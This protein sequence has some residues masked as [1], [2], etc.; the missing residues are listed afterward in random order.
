[1]GVVVKSCLGEVIETFEEGEIQL[2]LQFQ[3]FS[4]ASL[5]S[6]STESS[7]I[8]AFLR[9]PPRNSRA[10]RTVTFPDGVVVSELVELVQPTRT[11]VPRQTA[12]ALRAIGVEP[13]AEP[14]DGANNAV[15]VSRM[16]ARVA[17]NGSD[18]A[19]PRLIC[20]AVVNQARVTLDRLERAL[21]DR[22]LELECAPWRFGRLQQYTVVSLHGPP[23]AFG[24]AVDAFRSEFLHALGLLALVGVFVV[25][26]AGRAFEGTSWDSWDAHLGVLLAGWTVGVVYACDAAS[27]QIRRR[28]HPTGGLINHLTRDL[29]G[30]WLFMRSSTQYDLHLNLF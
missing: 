29:R 12:G 23:Q 19:S 24:G 16:M 7:R 10:E 9:L 26:A 18:A 4:D 27:L 1:M 13:A 6:R 2:K 14:A 25:G 11:W 15:L 21:W 28:R 22:A 5:R 17:G 30:G 20:S 8:P 3:L